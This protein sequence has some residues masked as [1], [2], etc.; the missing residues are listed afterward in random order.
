MKKIFVA[1][2]A[3]IL[4]VGIAFADDAGERSIHWLGFNIPVQNQTWSYTEDHYF[5]DDYNTNLDWEYDITT[6]GFNIFYNH[7]KVNDNRFSKILDVQLGYNSFDVTEWTVEDKVPA[8]YAI[9][10]N[11]L[12]AFNMRYMFG[13]GGAPLN[14]DRVVLAIHGTF[15]VDMKIAHGSDTYM[16]FDIDSTFFGL[17]TFIGANVQ[18]AVRLGDSIGLSAGMMMYTNLF[19]VGI[20]NYSVDSDLGDIIGDDS[21]TVAALI[22]PGQFNIDF[23]FGVCWVY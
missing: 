6:V 5:E 22:E 11:D 19:G 20:R 3:A 21:D 23:K 10:P 18:C 9:W 17:S 8:D 4:S 2:A 14:I 7:L 12:N 16:G 13:L 1:L 15:G